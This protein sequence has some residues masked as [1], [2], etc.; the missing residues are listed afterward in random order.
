MNMKSYL[1][2]G[3]AAAGLTLAT[4]A[5]HA[6]HILSI[7]EFTAPDQVVIQTTVGT[8]TL[9]D[10][11]PDGSPQANGIIGQYRDL[12]TEVFVANIPQSSV[13]S[14]GFSN[15]YFTHGQGPGVQST[16][17]LEWNG[18]A[19]AGLSADLSTYDQIEINL[20]SA[21]LAISWRFEF[22]DGDGSIWEGFSDT[23]PG[24]AIITVPLA[25][26]SEQVAGGTS[27]L[28][29]TDIDSIRLFANITQ[30]GAFDTEV[31]YIRLVD[32][33]EPATL[34]ILGAGL[35]GLGAIARRRRKS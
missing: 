17:T 5:A 1:M 27:G 13:A 14:A 34:S 31:D 11:A 26:F 24:G 4:S 28:D 19:G 6:S 12:T 21:D 8:T 10:N 20:V 25:A 22:E 35:I 15:G 23:L 30:V 3:V 7:D 29:L 16:T 33:P 18:L 2:A 9:L 32:T